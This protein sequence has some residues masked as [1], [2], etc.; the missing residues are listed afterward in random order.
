[1]STPYDPNQYHPPGN[2]PAYDPSLSPYGNPSSGSYPAQGPQTGSQPYGAPQYGPGDQ[3]QAYGQPQYG[4]PHAQGQQYGHD[5]PYGQSQPPYGGRPPYGAPGFGGPPPQQPGNKK[6]WIIGGAVLGV[7]A[8]AATIL[9]IV[10]NKDD[11]SDDTNKASTSG[12]PSGGG[13]SLS[14][15]PDD[16]GI[17]VDPKTGDTITCEGDTKGQEGAQ[18]LSDALNGSWTVEL[19]ITELDG[20]LIDSSGKNLGPGDSPYSA[21]DTWMV[22]GGYC[23]DAQSCTANAGTADGSLELKL[24]GDK[25]VAETTIK[26]W[27][28]TSKTTS[29]LSDVKYEIEAK[30]DTTL[31]GTRTVSDNGECGSVFHE[32]DDLIMN[33][34]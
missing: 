15:G 10:L 19:T 31:K 32:V 5:Q 14:C 29:S 26:Y 4:E 23:P 34:S 18:K 7:L 33:K 3:T 2:Q 22:L 28:D 17:K 16:Y 1:M 12:G 21:P 13:S 8:I 24:D 25:W 11:K 6:P 9:I 27:C 20:E 30:E